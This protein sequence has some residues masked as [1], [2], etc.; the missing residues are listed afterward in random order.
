MANRN[1]AAVRKLF[2]WCVARDIIQVSP[3]TLID[4]PAPER[5]RDR[6]LTDNALRLVWNAAHADGCPR[7]F[8]EA[9]AAAADLRALD[10]GRLVGIY[11]SRPM[12]ES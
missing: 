8:L 4:P 10:S 9:R 3:C 5:S 1:L 6:I 12:G 7:Q 2:S 11:F